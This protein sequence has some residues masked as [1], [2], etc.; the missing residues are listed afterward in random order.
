[1]VK[2]RIIILI[3]RR[4]SILSGFIPGFSILLFYI[5]KAEMVLPGI[6]I[7]Q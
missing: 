1:M 3:I 7:Y 6:G 5:F 2:R 4:S